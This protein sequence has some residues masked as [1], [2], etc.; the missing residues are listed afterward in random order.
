MLKVQ[1]LLKP[2]VIITRYLDQP[3][4]TAQIPR[5]ALLA[6]GQFPGLT[7]QVPGRLLRRATFTNTTAVPLA[8]INRVQTNWLTHFYLIGF[9]MINVV[10]VIYRDSS[11]AQSHQ[12]TF[13]FNKLSPTPMTVLIAG[14]FLITIMF[15]LLLLTH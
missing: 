5:H 9:P 12:N 1:S 10:R 2:F 13:Q 15:T 7:G 11:I 4:A 8:K 14:Q 3:H 6:P